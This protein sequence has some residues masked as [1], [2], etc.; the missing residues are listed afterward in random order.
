MTEQCDDEILKQYGISGCTD[1]SFPLKSE[2]PVLL[3]I[4]RMLFQLVNPYGI[5]DNP[6]VW[7]R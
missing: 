6:Y 1:V 4:I 3:K 2:Q 7:K 5:L